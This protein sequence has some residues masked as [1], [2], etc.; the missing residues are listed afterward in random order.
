VKNRLYS[1]EG[2]LSLFNIDFS[3]LETETAEERLENLRQGDVYR[4]RT[5]TIKAGGMLECEI[6]PVWKTQ[7]EAGRA[8]KEKPSRIAQENL[9]RKNNQ[10]KIMRLTNNNFTSADIWGS[11]GYDDENLPETPEQARRDMVNFL[12]RV[13]NKRK[14]QGLP[15]LRYIYVTEWKK[16]NE[17][18]G[19]A[20]RAHHHV[21]L[22]GD[23][24]RDE[25]ERLW[26]GGAYPQTRRLRVKEDCG[27]N[28]LACYISK[29]SRNEKMWGH[30][31]NLKLPVATVADRKITPHKAGI[32]A[33]NQA[34]APTLFEKLYKGYTCKSVDVK[35]SEF[36]AGF[37]IYVQM[38][39]KEPTSDKKKHKER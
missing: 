6:F 5:K 27:L 39:R 31:T 38:Y 33:Q 9:N 16:D 15:P 1:C 37:Y 26:S 4:Y 29:G 17:G 10:K 32:I 11:F 36:V 19:G 14:K 23:M 12:R 28:G 25:I 7:T 24:D 20:I 35:S 2:L 21:I 34:D 8:K 22:S 13:K 30:S 3:P 18:K